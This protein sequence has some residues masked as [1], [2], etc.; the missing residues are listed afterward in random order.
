MKDKKVFAGSA[1]VTCTIYGLAYQVSSSPSHIRALIFIVCVWAFVTI[2][3]LASFWAMRK[4][5]ER[6]AGNAGNAGKKRP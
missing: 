5:E 6:N 4:D 1:V 3:T 2:S